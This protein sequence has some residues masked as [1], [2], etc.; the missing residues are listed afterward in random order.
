MEKWN[1]TEIKDDLEIKY[2]KKE[3]SSLFKIALKMENK[4]DKSER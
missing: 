2:L 3:L 4:L 1:S